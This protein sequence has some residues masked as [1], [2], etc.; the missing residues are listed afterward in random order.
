MVSTVAKHLRWT[1]PL[2]LVGVTTNWWPDIQVAC[3]IRGWLARPFIGECGKGLELGSN[4][5]ILCSYNLSV[6]T[7]V[8]IA[9]GAWLN[10]AGGLTIQ[11]EVILGPYVVI[12]TAQHRM[13]NDSFRFAP[14]KL[15]PVVLG[16]GSWLAAH[17]SIKCGVTLGVANLVAANAAVTRDTPD[18]VLVA[19][20][21]ATPVRVLQ[22]EDGPLNIKQYAT[23]RNATAA[24]ER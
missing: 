13:E 23:P 6:G 1:L 7:N 11:D 24:Y 12:S 18:R 17:V 3:R 10:C 22:S 8:Y 15:A 5:T 19:G 14:S 16:R 4:V 20:A 9:R 21:P 2:W